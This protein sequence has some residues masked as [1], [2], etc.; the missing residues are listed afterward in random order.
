MVSVRMVDLL[1]YMTKYNVVII[2]YWNYSLRLEYIHYI[3]KVLIQALHCQI[4]AWFAGLPI[5]RRKERI[6]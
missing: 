1:F 5:V 4:M 2:T 3:L 6:Q